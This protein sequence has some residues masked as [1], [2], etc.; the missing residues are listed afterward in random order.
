MESGVLTGEEGVR[1]TATITRQQQRLLRAL[2]ARHKVSVAWLIRHAI[3]RLL[4]EGESLQLPL[5]LGS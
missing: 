1:V 2:A 3:D 5:D 4:S